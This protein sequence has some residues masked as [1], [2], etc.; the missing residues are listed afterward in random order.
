MVA[1][2]TLSF[3]ENSVRFFSSWLHIGCRSL[4]DEI[5]QRHPRGTPEAP[6]R[7][8]RGTAGVSQSPLQV[9]RNARIACYRESGEKA[10][11][12]GVRERMPPTE[13]QHADWWWEEIPGVSQEIVKCGV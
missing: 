12:G 10:S 1:I 5:P 8:L 4:A 7:H 3:D 6:Q 11:A 2:S 9:C 13:A